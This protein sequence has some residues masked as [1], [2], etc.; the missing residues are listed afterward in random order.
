MWARE[1]PSWFFA[2]G[3]LSSSFSI[4]IPAMLLRAPLAR[5]FYALALNR[6][7]RES[8]LVL[9]MLADRTTHEAIRLAK[10]ILRQ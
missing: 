1:S 5:P 7:F 10:R 2:E 9:P 3:P 4:G 8:F 6:A